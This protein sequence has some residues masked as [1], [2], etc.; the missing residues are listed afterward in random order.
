MPHRALAEKR[1]YLLGSIAAA[2]AFFVLRD[3][4]FPGAALILI[5]G[6]AVG[7]L[8]VYALVRHFSRDA[9]HV[10]AIMGVSAAGDMALELDM[11]WGGLLF[12]GGH[13]L[14]LALF[15]QP[16]NRR[17]HLTGSQK[18]T[19]VTLLLGVPLLAWLF[20][21]AAD[22]ALYALALGGM[23]GAAWTSRFSR[24]HVGIGAL[25]YAGSDLL[26]FSQMGPFDAG[27]VAEWLIWPCYYIGQFLICTGVIQTLRRDHQA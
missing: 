6:A 19:A 17:H 25:F 13:I 9:R 23:A 21:G 12:F 14:A 16:H 8:A 7:L 15:L 22:V 5:K 20:S 10:A 1:P 24:Y 2:L 18:A 11:F 3:D 27:I 26:I 4:Y